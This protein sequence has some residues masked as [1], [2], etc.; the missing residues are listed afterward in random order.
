[1]KYEVY[2]WMLTLHSLSL[3]KSLIYPHVFSELMASMIN[4]HVSPLDFA[5]ASL[6]WLSLVRSAVVSISINHSSYFVELCL[7]K[8]TMSCSREFVRYVCFCVAHSVSVYWHTTS[9]NAVLGL[10]SVVSW[11]WKRNS[12]VPNLGS[13]CGPVPL[14]ADLLWL[15][16]IVISY[17][18]LLQVCLSLPDCGEGDDW[19]SHPLLILQKQS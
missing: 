14:L 7:L 5:L 18:F 15:L 6:A 16:F 10:K 2:V 17:L 8:M 4:V 12:V 9:P 1:M 19:G 13:L 3:S 11:A